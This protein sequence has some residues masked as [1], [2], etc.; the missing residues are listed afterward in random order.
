MEGEDFVSPVDP[1]L[2]LVSGF[3]KFQGVCKFRMGSEY[4]F[5]DLLD[6]IR[7]ADFIVAHGGKHELQWLKR[8]GLDLT[9]I[10]IYD[11]AIGEFVLLGNRRAPLDFDSVSRRYGGSGKNPTY[12]RLMKECK[13][14]PSLWPDKWLEDYNAEDV[15]G[16]EPIF[17]AQ[18]EK[19]RERGL[20]P[21]MYTR[22][23]I[24]PMLADVEWNGTQ[25]DKSRVDHIY[26]KLMKEYNQIIGELNALTGGINMNSPKQVA[27]YLYLTLG[28]PIPPKKGPIKLGEPR[29]GTPIGPTGEEAILALR[30]TTEAQVRFIELKKRQAYLNAK[31]TKSFQK[32]VDCVN[33]PETRGLLQF[34]FN[35]MVAMNHRL[36][37]SGTKF[38]VQGQNIDREVKPVVT[39][40]NPGWKVGEWDYAG[41]EFRVAAFLTQDPV[42]IRGIIE[43]EDIHSYTASIIFREELI[44]DNGGLMPD[45]PTIKRKFDTTW[46]QESKP[47]TFSPLYFA[48]SG[49]NAQL[50]Y[51]DA[52]RKKYSVMFNAQMGWCYEALN[53]KKVRT[54]TGLTFY[55]PD[56]KMEKKWDRRTRKEVQRVKNRRNI[57]NYP[58]S[59]LATADMS[60]IGTVCM[61]HRMKSL[62]VQSF[63]TMLI[64]DA[65][66]AEVHPDEIKLMNGLAQQGMV[67]D[68]LVYLRLCYGIDFNVP[69][70]IEG[71]IGDFWKSKK[72]WE[73][74]WLQ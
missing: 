63:M 73:E 62:G 54:I 19:L 14:C 48:E 58:I 5:G 20:L 64:H 57:F 2:R 45:M 12:S 8:C 35:Q 51:Y 47:E 31:I 7:R 39:V 40:R 11:T 17:L 72:S 71:T 10:R 69:V 3:W 42:A 21:T 70:E 23:L 52:F 33:D 55:W 61:W 66:V 32:F 46:R 9:K 27:D 1:S 56:T 38:G 15:T 18:R 68:M 43:K 26:Q 41:I 28:F 34:R 59:S 29:K 37:S 22:C 25:L 67:D 13:V 44:R 65:V 36:S 60:Q 16:L 6:D 4:Q 49:T 74:H 30:P 53:T 24:T 50:D